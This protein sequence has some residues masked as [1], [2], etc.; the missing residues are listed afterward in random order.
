LR[1]RFKR[2]GY[3]SPRHQSRVFSIS[4]RYLHLG[5]AEVIALAT[6]VKADVVLID[7]QEGRQIAARTGLSVIG[8][9]GILLRAKLRGEI[10][11]LKPEILALR[12]N[13]RFFIASSLEARI[14]LA[15]G[16]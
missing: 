8:V 16:E 15:A 14:L 1:L 3:N 5:E 13:A 7:E 11:A 12:V 2:N 10:S 6:D 4:C 9:L